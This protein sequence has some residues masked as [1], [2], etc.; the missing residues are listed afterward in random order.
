MSVVPDPWYQAYEYDG[1]KAYKHGIDH[2]R[3][4]GAQ[5]GFILSIVTVD[6]SIADC[7]DCGHAGVHHVGTMASGG[8]FYVAPDQVESVAHVYLFILLVVTLGVVVT[9]V[10]LW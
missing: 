10:L 6:D 9:F 5:P 2:Y 8:W 3:H 4:V 7:G 1:H